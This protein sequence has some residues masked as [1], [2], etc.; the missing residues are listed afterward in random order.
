MLSMR[1]VEQRLMPGAVACRA[2]PGWIHNAA[3]SRRRLTLATG[4]MLENGY[5]IAA[6]AC[7]TAALKVAGGVR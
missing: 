4:C 5:A 6:A 3:S 1:L 7:Q 2:G